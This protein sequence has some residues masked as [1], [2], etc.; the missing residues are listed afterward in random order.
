M[1]RVARREILDEDQVGVYHVYNRTCRRSYLHG[2][3]PLTGVDH[4]HRRQW[5]LER[6]RFLA[7][8]FAI[9]VLG[10]AIMSNHWHCVLR[11]RPDMVE[12]MSNREVAMRW[13]GITKRQQGNG[14]TRKK[15]PEKA[16]NALLGD[17]KRIAEL[18]K[19][20]SSISWFVRLM[21]QTVAR[22][23]NLEDECT[24]RF[25]E[26]RF[27]LSKLETNE[28]VLAC[29]AYVDLNPIRAGL[30]DTLDD[31]N[32]QVSIGERLRGLDD[33]GVEPSSWLAPLE[34][35]EEVNKQSVEVTNRLSLDEVQRRRAELSRSMGCIPMTLDDYSNLLT[36]LAIEARPEL[37]AQ[38]RL[39]LEVVRGKL[40]LEDRSVDLEALRESLAELSVR[41][42]ASLGQHACKAIREKL[43][44]EPASAHDSSTSTVRRKPI[45]R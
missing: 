11:N 21:C 4:S 36:H 19:R 8:N 45:P 15:I 16:I 40:Q 35:Q 17:K 41:C 23:C 25:F 7:K 38:M 12:G 27:K 20:L 9:D 26:E 2:I 30:S 29:M 6:M 18:R 13:L 22:Q 3:D 33:H 34:M 32:A 42:D 39:S 14:K 31:A 24:G 1:A 5:F 44:G 37:Q 10:Y 43:A 28:D